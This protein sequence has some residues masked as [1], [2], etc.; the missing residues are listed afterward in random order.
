MEAVNSGPLSPTTKSAAP[1]ASPSPDEVSPVTG[2]VIMQSELWPSLG[3][4]RF[5]NGNSFGFLRS[6][7]DCFPFDPLY[8][9]VAD[10]TIAVADDIIAVVSE[11]RDR[12]VANVVAPTDLSE[13]LTS[14]TPCH[15]LRALM[16]RQLQL[17]SEPNAPGLRSLAAFIGPRADELSLE[18]S[19]ATQDR[20]HQSPMGCCCVGP[21]I[22]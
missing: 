11:P 2:A 6:G 1:V 8:S 16:C 5:A 22:C 21:G 10:D 4:N 7:A 3:A 13:C 12:R 9:A 20:Q 17:A 15:R 19:K 18:F 14:I